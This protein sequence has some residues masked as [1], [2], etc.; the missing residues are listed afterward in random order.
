MEIVPKAIKIIPLSQ[1]SQL[2]QRRNSRNCLIK[3]VNVPAIA[4]GM[5]EPIAYANNNSVPNR[6]LPE[7]DTQANNVTNTGVLQG[8]ATNPKDKPIKSDRQDFGKF[9]DISQLPKLGNRKAMTS[10]SCNPI[11]IAIMP[12]TIDQPQA[13]CP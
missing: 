3:P 11:V 4:K 13:V 9:G 2:D 5:T 7:P 12:M 6:I 8:E 10:N 1:F